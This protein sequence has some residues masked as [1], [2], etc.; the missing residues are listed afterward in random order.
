MK[1][2][3]LVAVFAVVVG[4]SSAFSP[5][6]A[7]PEGTVYDCIAI[8]PQSLAEQPGLTEDQARALKDEYK[9][10]PHVKVS[11]KKR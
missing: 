3:L 10:D 8:G 5:A 6:Y 1:K 4:L 7:A 11:C 9:A 2:K